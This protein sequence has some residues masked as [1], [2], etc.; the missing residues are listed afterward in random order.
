MGKSWNTNGKD[1]YRYDS[2]FVPN[3]AKKRNNQSKNNK[4]VRI[5]KDKELLSA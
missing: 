2:E 3:K 1:K 4:W 5:D